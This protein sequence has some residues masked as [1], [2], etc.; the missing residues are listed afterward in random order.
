MHDT[1]M[2]YGR[3]FF[4]AYTKNRKN[5]T[6]VDIG[7]QDFNGSLRSAAPANHRYVG[8]D[9]EKGKGVDIVNEDPYS[10]PFE[11]AS[12]D[13]VV[14]SSCFEHCEFFWLIFNEC[15]RVLKPSGLLYIN[16]PSNGPFHRFPQDCWRFYPDSGLALQNWGRKSG[17]ES[18]TMLE[19][20]IGIQARDVWNDFVAVFVKEEKHIKDYPV[21][22]QDTMKRYLN[23]LVFGSKEVTNYSELS[24]DQAAHANLKRLAAVMAND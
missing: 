11:D 14:S 23:G 9:S 17:Y 1:A 15:L 20:F 5:L 12:V 4:T 13:I 18:V 7:A 22:I 3:Q 2:E 8:V 19:S 21:R 16:V 24:Q 10:L 6:I